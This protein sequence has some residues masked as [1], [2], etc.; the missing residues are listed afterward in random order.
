MVECSNFDR[1]GSGDRERGAFRFGFI[2]WKLKVNKRKW[3]GKVVNFT[4]FGK[5][6]D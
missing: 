3:N 4:I 5:F 2:L 1:D 6:R